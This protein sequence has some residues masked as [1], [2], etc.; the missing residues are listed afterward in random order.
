MS[1]VQVR[2]LVAFLTGHARVLKHLRKMNLSNTDL[3]RICEAETET[4]QHILCECS[5]LENR[6]R[7]YFGSLNSQLNPT[8]LFR[9]QLHTIYDFLK[10]IGIVKEEYNLG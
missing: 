7:R 8:A 4:A 9:F 3:C 6:R 1:V 5:G 10:G 2:V